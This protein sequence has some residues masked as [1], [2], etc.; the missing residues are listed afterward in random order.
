MFTL[1]LVRPEDELLIEAREVTKEAD[2]I[3]VQTA[4][5]TEWYGPHGQ[6]MALDCPTRTNDQCA[7]SGGTATAYVMNR[8]G[9]TVAT[10]R[11]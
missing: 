4:D 10:Y 11:L 3:L 6:R 2:G 5:D 8:F 7:Q 9:A 1:K